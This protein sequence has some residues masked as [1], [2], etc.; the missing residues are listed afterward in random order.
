VTNESSHF[1]KLGPTPLTRLSPSR[2]RNGPRFIRSAAIRFAIVGVTPGSESI[3][4]AVATSR[5]SFPLT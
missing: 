2:F 1:A 4:A 5:S 3:C